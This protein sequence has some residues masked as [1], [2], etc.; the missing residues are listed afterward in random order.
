MKSQAQSI[1]SR[2]ETSF[3]P[4][5]ND[6]SAFTLMELLVVIAIIAIL[7][8]LMLPT[9]ANAKAKGQ[10]VNCTNNLKQLQ[11]AW[12]MYVHDEND[13]LPPNISRYS[14]SQ[15]SQP[16]S[17]VLG[18]AQ[19]DTVT[20][21]IQ[22]GVLFKYINAVGVYRCPGD[23]SVVSR[24][25][26]VPRTRSY[27]LSFYMNCDGEFL[28]DGFHY[29]PQT[30]PWTKAK[31]THFINPPV[32]QMFTFIE[33]NEQSI[34]DGVFLAPNLAHDQVWWD[35]PSDRHSQA[36]NIAFADGRVERHK[37]KWPKMFAQHGQP[38]ASAARDPQHLDL[39]DLRWLESCVPL[40]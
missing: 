19:L 25:A 14:G 40:Q 36:S 15:Q 20:S 29:S 35:L 23:R 37:W 6:S 7:A 21:N 28:N 16:G 34:D 2:L 5:R 11:T 12:L 1:T 22:N 32:N 24:T 33:E 8:S 10:A 39:Q 30:F 9:L 31:L 4:V 18:N 38:Y 27:S 13:S 17:W 26:G 3:V